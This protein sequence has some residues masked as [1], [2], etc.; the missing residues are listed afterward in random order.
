MDENYKLY[1]GNTKEVIERPT[2]IVVKNR[3]GSKFLLNLMFNMNPSPATHSK[4][5][6]D[7]ASGIRKRA[8]DQGSLSDNG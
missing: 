5:R 7:N 4:V 6:C 8:T 1:L 3:K 2:K